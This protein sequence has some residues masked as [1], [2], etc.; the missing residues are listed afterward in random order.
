MAEVDYLIRV[1]KNHS[2]VVKSF[3]LSNKR[4]EI[5]DVFPQEK[6]V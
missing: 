2:K 5:V 6:H 4:T 1:Q 3:I